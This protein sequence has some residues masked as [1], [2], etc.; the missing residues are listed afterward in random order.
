M[1]SF[2][3]IDYIAPPDYALR[4]SRNKLHSMIIVGSMGSGKT[5]WTLSLIARAVEELQKR[6]KDAKE[7]AVVHSLEVGMNKAVREV[8]SSLDLRRIKYLYWFSDDAPAA[9]G[10]HGRRAM[11]R[12][13][14]EES[15]FY[16]VIR[17]R[18]EK[19]GFDGFVFAAHA[20]Q[21]YHLVDVT[22]RRL[23]KIKAFKDYPD[24]PADLKVVG[25]MLGKAYLRKL[26]EITYKIWA[27]RSKAELVE[28]L[29]SAVVRFIRKKK[30]VT[31]NKK[32]LPDDVTYLRIEPEDRGAEDRVQSTKVQ[33]MEYIIKRMR[34][35]R[36]KKVL[37]LTGKYVYIKTDG[38]E[39]PFIKRD[40]AEALGII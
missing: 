36:E 28:G 23:S 31:I 34:K 25:P 32:P 38:K 2:S 19:L 6:G 26:A 8:C 17:H 30:V 16:T 12:E 11:S 37:K 29:S 13:N 27:P 7:I 10:M 5:T 20:T 4:V 39:V 24:E 3:M 21:V 35:L 40:T 14:V 33:Y 1:T 9:E 22:F 15:T 18:L